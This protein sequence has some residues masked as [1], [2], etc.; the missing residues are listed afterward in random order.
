MENTVQLAIKHVDVNLVNQFK[1]MCN[2][3]NLSQKD[4][5]TEVLTKFFEKEVAADVPSPQPKPS[6]LPKVNEKVDKIATQ[7]TDVYNSQK[8]VQENIAKV[9]TTAEI[10][11]LST[12]ITEI[13]KLVKPKPSKSKVKNEVKSVTYTVDEIA[14]LKQWRLTRERWHLFGGVVFGVIMGI[15]IGQYVGVWFNFF[16]MLFN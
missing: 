1:D 11:A 4:G 9:A 15:V 8:A 5:I 13:L 2:D 10:K 3:R 12:D 14:E 16:A 6:I 7:L